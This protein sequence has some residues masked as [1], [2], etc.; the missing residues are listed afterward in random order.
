[1][2]LVNSPLDEEILGESSAIRIISQSLK[3]DFTS[4]QQNRYSSTLSI[5][6]IEVLLENRIW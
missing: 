1:M 5:E 3:I 6:K 4:E 2:N